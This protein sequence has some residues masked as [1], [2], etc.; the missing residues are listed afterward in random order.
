MNVRHTHLTDDRL[1]AACLDSVPQAGWLE[2]CAVCEERRA[3]LAAMLAEIGETA[4]AEADAAFP[5]DRLARQCARILHR[6]DQHGRHGRVIAFP[7]HANEPRILRTRLASRWVAGAA[8]AGLAIG[9]LGGYLARNA[10]EQRDL[11]VGR[12]SVTAVPR[13]GAAGIVKVPLPISDDE[14]LGQ[15]DLVADGPGATSLR[16]L[17]DLTPAAWDVQ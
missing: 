6:L 3:A 2:E 1:I 4:R 11:S 7:V 5:A 14:F 16:S 17:H 15:I 9:L 8:A 13:D 10:S 12:F